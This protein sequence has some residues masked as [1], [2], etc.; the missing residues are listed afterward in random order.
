MA[1]SDDQIRAVTVGELGPEYKRI[2]IVDYD[3]RWPERYAI[4]AKKI[5]A[6]LGS[7]IVRLEHAGSTSVPGLAAKPIIDIVLEV[8]DSSD[9][10][11]YA[12]AL[13]AAGYALRIRE[14]DWHQHRMF[15]GED[16]HLH[17]YSK[18][19]PEADRVLL[20]RDWLSAHP[21]DRGLYERTKRE[22]AKR[23]W[24]HGQ[25]Y[26]DAKTDV[27]SEILGRALHRS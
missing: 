14:P 6:A 8:A 21:E 12:P 5:R 3:P 22:L 13:E 18:G 9:E 16:L 19:C 1:I 25:Y 11:A 7:K 17:V 23:E 26:A 10:P 24:K 2:V 4:E 15:K 20:F 27:I